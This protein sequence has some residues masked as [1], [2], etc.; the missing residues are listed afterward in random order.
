[1]EIFFIEFPDNLSVLTLNVLI[2]D[3]RD[4]LVVV[5]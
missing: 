2:R 1:M 4:G 3:V 5:Q